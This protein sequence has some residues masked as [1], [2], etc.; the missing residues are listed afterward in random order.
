MKITIE[1]NIAGDQLTSYDGNADWHEVTIVVSSAVARLYATQ[2]GEPHSATLDIRDYNGT[3]RGA[4][5]LEI[6]D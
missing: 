3:R 1:L 4:A 5:S 2:T 6:A